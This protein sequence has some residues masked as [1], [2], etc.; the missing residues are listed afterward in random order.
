MNLRPQDLLLSHE[1]TLMNVRPQDLLLSHEPTLWFWLGFINRTIFLDH[2][3]PQ[4][5]TESLESH[6]GAV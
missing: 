5:A 3:V 6:D 2:K 4:S 1:P